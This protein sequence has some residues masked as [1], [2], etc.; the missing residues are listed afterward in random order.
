MPGVNRPPHE[1]D[2]DSNDRGAHTAIRPPQVRLWLSS[3]FDEKSRV[4]HFEALKQ[5]STTHSQLGTRQNSIVRFY[6]DLV[7]DI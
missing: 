3:F 2:T 7:K 5:T 4:I 6:L 1:G